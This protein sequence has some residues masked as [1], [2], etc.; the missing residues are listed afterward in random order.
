[1]KTSIKRV[2][3]LFILLSVAQL[4]YSQGMQLGEVLIVTR[5]ELKN[6]V[7][8]EDLRSYIDQHI[9]PAWNDKKQGVN[10]HLFEAD[11]GKGKG[12]FLLVCR[13]KK[14]A[15]RKASLP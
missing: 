10:F 11:R 14:I 8:K 4:S 2:S 5:P 7:S 15:D 12:E 6:G 9:V 1:M 3:F 13:L